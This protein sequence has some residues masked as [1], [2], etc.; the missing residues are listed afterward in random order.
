[1]PSK[2]KILERAQAL[3]RDEFYTRRED[4]EKELRHYPHHFRNKTVYLNCDDPTVSN[5]FHYFSLNFKPLGLRKLI[6]TCY[7]SQNRDM[8]SK[9]DQERAIRLEYTGTIAANQVPGVDDIPH[10]LMGGDGDF[11]SDECIELLHKADIV[12][13]NP[14]FSLFIEYLAQLIKHQ[15]KFLILGPMTAISYKEVFPLIKDEKVWLGVENGRKWFEVGPDYEASSAKGLKLEDGKTLISMGNVIWYTNLDHG[16]RHDELMLY[17]K[18]KEE[19]YPRYDNYPD[20]IEV[21]KVENI[22]VD[23]K[24]EMGV[25]ISFLDKHNPKQFEIV[26]MCKPMVAARTGRSSGFKIRGNEKFARIVIKWRQ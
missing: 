1:M 20:A 25:P 5:F 19:E 3:K 26:G 4:V 22:P 9:H 13:T 11:R 24:G 7:K 21:G 15:K 2:K 12:V 17:R 23:F 16:G 14:P 8:F 18:Y 10:H 6:A